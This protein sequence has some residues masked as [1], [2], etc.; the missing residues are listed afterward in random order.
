M[1]LWFED[2]EVGQVF[3]TESVVVKREAI[4]D[5][6]RLTGDDNPLHTDAQMMRD[7]PYGDVIA[8]GLFVQSLAVGLIAKLGIME[9]TTLALAEINSRFVAPVVPGDEIH[10]AMTIEEK[11]ESRKPDRGVVIRAVDVLNQR[12]DTAV[13]ARMVSIMRRRGSK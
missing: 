2:F 5:F 13:A 3:E 8:H 12:G 11:R 4:I 1:G 7:S 10:V 6:A 9:G